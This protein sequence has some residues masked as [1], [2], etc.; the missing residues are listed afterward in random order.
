MNTHRYG[1][2]LLAAIA[3]FLTSTAARAQTAQ[4]S[5]TRADLQSAV[6]AYLVAQRSG[7]PASL[8]L[9]ASAKYIENTVDA[10]LDRGS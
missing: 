2:P 8:P 7:N 6:D 3:I 1:V 5:C 10:P 4:A 9:T